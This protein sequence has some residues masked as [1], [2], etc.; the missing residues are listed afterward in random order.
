MEWLVFFAGGQPREIGGDLFMGI[1]LKWKIWQNIREHVAYGFTNT[2]VYMS[3]GP[4]AFYSRIRKDLIWSFQQPK[5]KDSLKF[6]SMPISGG[7][8]QFGL[9]PFSLIPLI[10]I[11]W[12]SSSS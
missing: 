4:R 6:G 11:S 5:K 3:V 2:R 10:I 7:R 9:C 1:K 12:W 8:S